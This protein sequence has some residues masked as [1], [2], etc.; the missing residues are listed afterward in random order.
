MKWADFVK[1]RVVQNT[2]V[3]NV[4]KPVANVACRGRDCRAPTHA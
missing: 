4:A 3:E 1:E 2:D